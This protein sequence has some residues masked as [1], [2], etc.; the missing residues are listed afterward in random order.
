MES[1]IV[2]RFNATIKQVESFWLENEKLDRKSYAILA[3]EKLGHLMGLA[4]SKYL[5]REV[6]YE[7][8]A[9]KYSDQY[10]VGFTYAPQSA[11]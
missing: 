2:P 5:K 6:D 10:L 4:M 3:Q 1:L 7:G 9:I 11:D 8:Y